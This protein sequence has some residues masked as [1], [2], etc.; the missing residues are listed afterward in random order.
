MNQQKRLYGTPLMMAM[1]CWHCI[2]HDEVRH[3]H[4]NREIGIAHILQSGASVNARGQNGETALLHT[5][6][7]NNYDFVSVLLAAGA[8]VM[9]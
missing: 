1:Y 7:C 6:Y 3:N 8:Y 9:L 2:D 4:R 5:S